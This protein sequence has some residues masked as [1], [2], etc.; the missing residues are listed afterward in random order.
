MPFQA[1]AVTPGL[2]RYGEVWGGM[3]IWVAL[4]LFYSDKIGLH[5]AR[6]IF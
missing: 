5:A 4:F 1:P 3:G 6:L 2:E